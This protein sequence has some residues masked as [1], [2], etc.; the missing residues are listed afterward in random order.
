MK[1]TIHHGLDKELARKATRKAFAAYKARFSE[2]KPEE[3]WLTEDM[4]EIAFSVKGLTLKG[5]V[6]VKEEEIEAE[7]N[8]PLVLRPFR[9]KALQ[10]IEDEVRVWVEKARRG[11][12]DEG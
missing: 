1:Q 11:E 6:E 9:K 8:V 12:L 2:Y 5:A 10:V 3:T 7:L 4:A